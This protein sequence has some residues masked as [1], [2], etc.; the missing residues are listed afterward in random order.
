MNK[1]FTLT[2]VQPLAGGVLQLGFADG[3][4]MRVE[5]APIVRRSPVLRALNDPAVFRR[6]KLGEW[7]GSVTWDDDLLELAA[8]NLRARAVEQAGGTSHEAVLDW[9]HRHGLTQQMAADA[10]G[11][12]RR[13]LGY[14][15][16]GAKSVPRTVGL[17]CK[18]WEAER[19]QA[20]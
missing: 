16:S 9:M 15:V 11:I 17:A 6:A 10:L 3:E 5:V 7:G 14:Y 12:S 13:M 18:G 2:A 19:R 20:A 1:Q 8:D 4:I